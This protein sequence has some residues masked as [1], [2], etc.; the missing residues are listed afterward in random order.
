MMTENERRLIVNQIAL[1]F[2]A[3]GGVLTVAYAI[4]FIFDTLKKWY[5]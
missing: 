5:W 4:Y 1:T 2:V 3:I